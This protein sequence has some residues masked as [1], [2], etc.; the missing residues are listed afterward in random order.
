[1]TRYGSDFISSSGYVIDIDETACTGCGVCEETCP[2][3]AISVDGD[4]AKVDWEKCLGCGACATQCPNDALS[5]ARD[6]RKGI[7]MDVRMLT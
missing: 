6:E 5:L 7:P 3:A 1:M 2:F 4:F